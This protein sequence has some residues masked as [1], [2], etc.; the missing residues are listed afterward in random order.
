MALTE[1]KKE[2]DPTV[3]IT[4]PVRLVFTKNLFEM[5]APT[6]KDKSITPEPK[7]SVTAIFDKHEDTR[8]SRDALRAAVLKAYGGELEKV[9]LSVKKMMFGKALDVTDS[10]FDPKICCF[11]DGSMEAEK[12]TDFDHSHY[13]DKIFI[14]VKTKD[15]PVLKSEKGFV[16]ESRDEGEK[17]GLWDGCYARLCLKA[18]AKESMSMTF[19]LIGLIVVSHPNAKRLAGGASKEEMMAELDAFISQDSDD[20]DDF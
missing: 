19:S 5:S 9:P 3:V 7:Y 4:P 13:D 6:M 14:N 18:F 1:K 2:K 20:E 10:T 8:T 11:Q 16:I 12:T 15:F 17:L